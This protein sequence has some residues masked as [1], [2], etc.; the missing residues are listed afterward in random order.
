MKNER[1]LKIL[2]L[3]AEKEI[4]TQEEL[5]AEL[6]QSGFSA[7]QATIS[8]DI[9]ELHLQKVSGKTGGTHYTVARDRQHGEERT[10]DKY[11]S[12]L[13]QVLTSAVPAGNI[14]VVKT[15]SGTA[16]AAAAALEAIRI[17]NII[18]TLAGDDTLLV[19]FANE[20]LAR[21]FCR[22]LNVLYIKD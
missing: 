7:T 2:E 18:G 13:H 11:C 8:R 19:L 6:K 21:E 22:D 9:K 12:V 5:S 20:H 10:R 16:N 15:L 17:E 1:Q 14:G 4:H 3:V